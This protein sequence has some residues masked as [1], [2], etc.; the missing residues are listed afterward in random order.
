MVKVK[1]L[2]N[3]TCEGFNIY[4]GVVTEVPENVA[5]ALGPTVEIIGKTEE[6]AFT[7]PPVDKMIKNPPKAKGKGKKQ[8]VK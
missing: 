1:G 8:V 2:A 4:P 5:N 6:K 3:V 7:A